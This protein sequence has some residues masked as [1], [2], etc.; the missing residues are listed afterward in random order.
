MIKRLIVSLLL[1]PAATFAQKKDM[2]YA[3]IALN[4]PGG[5]VTYN[6]GL[7]RHLGLGGG[8]DLYDLKE[9]WVNVRTAVY[10]DVRPNWRFGRSNIFIPIDLGWAFYGGHE[11]TNDPVTYSTNGFYTSL[12]LGYCYRL[13]RRGGGP[14]ATFMMK[15]YGHA[16]TGY[17]YLG[18]KYEGGVYEASSLISVGFKF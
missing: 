18:R 5:S 4:T 13:T 12:G 7:T 17:D 16:E 1:A 9:Y 8:A 15:G 14:Y 2:L 10:I 6:R 11:R 3:D